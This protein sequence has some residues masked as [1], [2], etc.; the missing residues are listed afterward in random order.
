[1]VE[2]GQFSGYSYGSCY[3]KSNNGY[4]NLIG[5]LCTCYMPGWKNEDNKWTKTKNL[6]RNNGG[7]RMSRKVV[8][9]QDNVQDILENKN[10]SEE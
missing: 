8:N 9:L 4:R 3:S 2:D 10:E 6:W 1:M 5:V 7:D